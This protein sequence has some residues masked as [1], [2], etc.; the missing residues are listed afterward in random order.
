M[1]PITPNNGAYL[2]NLLAQLKQAQAALQAQRT[3]YV[4]DEN[5]VCQ[6]IIG[7]LSHD[8]AGTATGLS[9]FGVASHHS[10]SWV[11]V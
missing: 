6:A 10:G 11:Q 9:G 3:Q 1:P 7:N 2:A 4:V 8:Q 5:G